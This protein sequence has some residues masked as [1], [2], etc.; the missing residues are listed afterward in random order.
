MPK[1]T[2]ENIVKPSFKLDKIKF[3]RLFYF[4]KKKSDIEITEM[5]EKRTGVKFSRMAIKKWRDEL[6]MKARNPHQR[7]QLASDKNRFNHMEVAKK[8]KYADRVINYDGVNQKRTLLLK[9]YKF[10]DST[11]GFGLE[12]Q[13]NAANK[14]NK[15]LAGYLG[16]SVHCIKSWCS[17]YNKI[18]KIYWGK[19]CNFLDCT[20]EQIFKISPK[21][22]NKKKQFRGHNT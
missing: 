3:I 16:V 4:V 9:N 18:N 5:I 14:N 22:A 11:Y 19:I 17:L 21:E 12:K 10:K 8:I 2:F 1:Y 7:F 13:L 20:K 15:Q 6:M